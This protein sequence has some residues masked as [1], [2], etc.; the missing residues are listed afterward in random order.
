MVSKGKSRNAGIGMCDITRP[1][2]SGGCRIAHPMNVRKLPHRHSSTIA[3]INKVCFDGFRIRSFASLLRMTLAMNSSFRLG[4]CSHRLDRRRSAPCSSGSPFLSGSRRLGRG[5]F[6]FTPR[7]LPL[8]SAQLSHPRL[9]APLPSA[10]GPAPRPLQET[11]HST[12]HPR[13][14]RATTV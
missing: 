6:R 1:N 4:G 5:L 8:S 12:R 7:K 11:S 3:I 13:A 10:A 9:C 14:P 2:F